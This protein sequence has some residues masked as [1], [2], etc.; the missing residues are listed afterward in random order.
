RGGDPVTAMARAAA[1]RLPRCTVAP[2]LVLAADAHDSVGM[3]PA[4]R[5]DNLAGRVQVRASVVFDH[6]EANVVLVDDV[7]TTGATAAES[8]RTLCRAQCPVSGV[9]V[10]AA[11]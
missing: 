10:V 1:R 6:V 3:S 2:V 8:V 7:L 11:A 4:A 9:I 5:R